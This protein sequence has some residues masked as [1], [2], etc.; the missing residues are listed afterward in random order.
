MF[1]VLLVAVLVAGPALGAVP[2][3]VTE[4]PQSVDSQPVIAV[5]QPEI[6]DLYPNPTA[7]GDAGEFV[8]LWLPPDTNLDAH[9]LGD[10]QATVQLSSLANTTA[11]GRAISTGGKNGGRYVTLSTDPE[12]TA[13]LTDRTALALP[14]QL[15]LANSG[16]T[17]RL[18]DNGTIVD[19]VSYEQAPDG[20]VYDAVNGTWRP[21]GATDRPVTTAGNGTVEAFVLPD[22]SERAVEFLETADERI[23]LAGY[24]L[25]SERVVDALRAA[26]R[27]NVRVEV[28]VEGNPVGGMTTRQAAA[29]DELRRAGVTV[30]VLGGERARYRYHHAKYAIVDD[31]ALVTTENWKASGVGGHSSR[32]WA[33]ITAQD[34]IVDGLVET[35]RADAGWQDTIPWDEFDP[36]RLTEPAGT[37]GE[38]PSKFENESLSVE[39]TQLLVTPDNADSVINDTIGSAQESLDIKQVSIANP[40]FVFL[41][42]VL[43]AARRGVKVRILLS[44]AWYVEEENRQ[45]KAWLDE[46]AD[47]EN[48]PLDV[49]IADPDGAFGKIH[50]K[51]IV[52][53]GETTILGSINWNENSLHENREVALLVESHAVADYF[54]AV[55][56]S[57]WE[58]DRKQVPLGYL[59]A[60]GLAAAIALFVAT[61]LRFDEQ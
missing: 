6:L 7:S 27:R 45:L 23:L 52:V 44:G 15:Q 36:G 32:G 28:L 9:A 59:A 5:D 11:V 14:D 8:T 48:L 29:L 60:C 16:E 39:R 40:R 55:F 54:G 53:D 35:Y 43:D 34:E 31:R 51:G 57:D 41:Q 25:S 26:S 42:A 38:Y 3:P 37:G 17:V 33:L 58:S 21:L 4:Q 1:P 10:E 22:E 20:E 13:E 2:V 61:R 46:Q 24:T 30:R 18:L 49:R 12:L 50:A 47:V 56:E 19:E